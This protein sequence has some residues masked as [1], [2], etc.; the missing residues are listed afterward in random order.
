LFGLEN[1]QILRKVRRK[2]VELNCDS[3]LPSELALQTTPAVTVTL[4]DI[5]I[6]Q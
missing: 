4:S 2:L 5:D 6:L 1:K 3:S